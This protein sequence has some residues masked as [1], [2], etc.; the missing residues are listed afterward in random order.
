MVVK[1]NGNKISSSSSA[2]TVVIPSV[3]VVTIQLASATPNP[4]T[5][6][7]V[8][9]EKDDSTSLSSATRITITTQPVKIITLHLALATPKTTSSSLSL[10]TSASSQ[11]P[12]SASKTTRSSFSYIIPYNETQ[13]CN[14]YGPICQTGSITVGV[15]LTST[16]TTT[17]L[18]CSSYLTAQSS[19]LQAFNPLP[20]AIKAFWPQEWKAGFGHS[21]QCTSYAEVWKKGGQYTFTD[22][23]SNNAVVQASEGIQLPSQIPPGVLRSIP[24]QVYECCGN[25]T[26]DVGRVKIFYW[27]DESNNSTGRSQINDISNKVDPSSTVSLSAD[28][29]EKRAEGVLDIAIINGYTL[30]VPSYCDLSYTLG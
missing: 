29:N 25:C 4:S 8:D 2:I 30:S 16:T 6:S 1:N 27:G 17:T 12:S 26:L 10:V 15:D 11:T 5:G 7:L 14:I 28:L 21:P 22:C 19:Y 23:G 20:G 3:K 18:P 13:K 24:F 9:G